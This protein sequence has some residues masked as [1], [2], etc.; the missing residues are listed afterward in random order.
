MRVC[1]ERIVWMRWAAVASYLAVTGCTVE[2]SAPGVEI[3]SDCV[4]GQQLIWDG[5]EIEC[6]EPAES[7]APDLADVLRRPASCADG[8]QLVWQGGALSCVAPSPAMPF[9][10]PAGCMVGEAL[11]WDGMGWGCRALPTVTPSGE[12]VCRGGQSLSWEGSG[13]GCGDDAALLIGPGGDFET[14]DEALGA[15]DAIR[16]P[17]GVTAVLKVDC[18][19]HPQPGP[20]RVEHPQGHAIHIVG[21]RSCGG[22][23][24]LRFDGSNGV[25]LTNGHQLGLLD[26]IKLS[27]DGEAGAVG[28]KI[29]AGGLLRLGQ[30]TTVANFSVGIE[31]TDG[32][33]LVAAPSNG[34]GVLIEGSGPSSTA[35]LATTDGLVVLPGLVSQDVGRGAEGATGAVIDV[36]GAI[37]AAGDDARP[38]ETGTVVAAY[39]GGIV[40]GHGIR[41]GGAFSAGVYAGDG[42]IVRFDDSS[43]T[44]DAID[45]AD[46]LISR[47]IFAVGSGLASGSDV[48]AAGMEHLTLTTTG[49]LALVDRLRWTGT[50]DSLISAFEATSGGIVVSRGYRDE[51]R[52]L[53]SAC[54]SDP[55]S[56]GCRRF[57]TADGDDAGLALSAQYG[58]LL[59]LEGVDVI[60]DVRAGHGAVLSVQ[61]LR[62]S[63]DETAIRAVAG[64]TI[65]LWGATVATVGLNALQAYYNASIY[66]ERL[67]LDSFHT[68]LRAV[69][70]GMIAAGNSEGPLIERSPEGVGDCVVAE[71]GGIVDI[72]SS[73]SGCSKAISASTGSVVNAR[74]AMIEG[75]IQMAAQAESG[76]TVDLTNAT[77]EGD[78]GES[79]GILAQHN[80]TIAADGARI[81]LALTAVTAHAAGV[82][83][84]TGRATRIEQSD[85]TMISSQFGSL[86][87]VSEAILTQA[88]GD[89]L[90]SVE[91]SIIRARSTEIRGTGSAA[92]RAEHNGYVS[93]YGGSVSDEIDIYRANCGGFAFFAPAGQDF[94]GAATDDCGEIAPRE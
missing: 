93:L 9:E 88:G 64:A 13:F 89:T 40:I 69:M 70:G 83:G 52:V 45:A 77:V 76:A 60:G 35:V 37:F 16:I 22:R 31:V 63:S 27:G 8:S 91:G 6:V 81:S 18:G 41:A 58:A 55:E 29:G 78:G 68:G 10:V 21:E 38:A 49:G 54:R 65:T 82:V 92:V 62:T 3:P 46:G 5:S 39:D 34:P 26:Q 94:E 48:N 2:A 19:E 71:S 44:L 14:I 74:G 11:V 66:A 23:P 17:R 53:I 20:L 7:E 51:Q 80:G 36:T 15:L 85:G 57:P 30:S 87:D 1:I 25:W 50:D 67:F 75:F 56:E 42:G 73:I 28:I 47:G 90:R 86:V 4:A 61:D 24:V 72:G 33:K 79:T 84:A 32:G 59:S 12:L 43:L